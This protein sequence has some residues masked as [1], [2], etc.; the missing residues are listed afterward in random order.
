[1]QTILTP[2]DKTKHVIDDISVPL[3]HQ[4]LS[5]W[6][7]YPRIEGP[8][9]QAQRQSDLD[10]IAKRAKTKTILA[11]GL[12]RSY[13]DAAANSN[14]ITILLESLNRLLAFNET[15][16]LLHVE[17]GVTIK[18]LLDIFVPR[19]WM[20]PVVPGTKHVTIGGAIAADIHGKNHYLT[21]SFSRHLEGLELFTG[22]GD[23]LWCS[24]QENPG[25]FW[26]T[27]GG[28]GLTGIIST[29][30]LHLTKIH[31]PYMS[32]QCR[33]AAN[34]SEL[35]S[36]F[37]NE[38]N[39][40]SYSVAWIDCLRP[41]KNFGRG[42]LFLGDHAA[43]SEPML[44]DKKSPSHVSRNYRVNIPAYAPSWLVNEYTIG[45][46]NE[47]YYFLNRKSA[48][49]KDIENFFFPL[50]AIHNWN[51][52]YGRSGLVQYQ[53]LIPLTNSIAGLPEILLKC[54]QS[55]YKPSLVV[56]KRLGAAETR[57]KASLSFADSGYTLTIDFAKR[58]G[59]LEFLIE[60]DSLVLKMGG[61]VYLAKDARLSAETF[62][63]M[64]PGWR[65]WQQMRNTLD[66]Q[67]MFHSNL[68]SRLG[69]I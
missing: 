20:I 25:A 2:L 49:F 30:K 31:S 44:F 41:I 40:H 10:D 9:Y 68:A 46:F 33:T 57:Q 1:V 18:T 43:K 19:G 32:T 51:R 58:R 23:R 11:R 3:C 8:V 53:F 66:P 37:N 55:P 5:G 52:L 65:Q 64:Y 60:L 67:H 24:R 16:G 48:R 22:T 6:A 12:G 54:A 42:I 62:Q 69:L 21:G 34:L 17:A 26:A 59:L 38:S 29:A 50:D 56:L 36:L 28:M 35:L 47:L 4:Q 14:G 61:R 15:T 63:S 13:G 39:D 7:G 45:T 27:I